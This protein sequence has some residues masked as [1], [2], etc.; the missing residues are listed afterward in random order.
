M[1]NAGPVALAIAFLCLLIWL[2]ASLAWTTARGGSRMPLYSAYRFDPYGSA[3]LARFLQVS[4]ERVTLLTHP[5]LPTHAAGVLVNITPPYKSGMLENYSTGK[6][7]NPPLLRWVA[8]GNALI[9]FTQNATGLT[10]HF[11]LRVAGLTWSRGP[12]LHRRHPLQHKK[13]GESPPPQRG[14]WMPMAVPRWITVMKHGESP[15]KLT[16]WMKEVRWK[17][18]YR[19]PGKRR[20]RLGNLQLLAPACF[21]IPKKD[22]HWKIL[23]ATKTGPVAIERPLGRGRVILVG[24]PWPVLNGGIGQ[25]GNLDF[26]RA[27]VGNKP[28]ILDQWSLGVGHNYTMLDVLRRYGLV[29]ALLELILLVVAYAWSCRGYPPSGSGAANTAARASVEHI[30]MLGQL[31]ENSLSEP[32]I[33][34]RVKNEITHRMAEAL[35][36]RPERIAERLQKQPDAVGQSFRL[37]LARLQTIERSVVA[38]PGTS[39]L[40]KAA[41]RRALAELMTQSWQ[42]AQEI[43]HGR[44]SGFQSQADHRVAGQGQGGNKEGDPRAGIAH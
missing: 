1:R 2:L 31:Y 6:H 7:Y 11:H 40:H 28:V 13:V 8:A 43:H 44:R 4:G 5:I 14:L 39:Q 41:R 35:R 25:A 34:E 23:A 37:M 19:A 29:P 15:H 42:L 26:L 24:S 30:A 18:R 27:L 10:E 22:T 21:I 20:K 36:S 38:T 32:E 9:D 33:L 3:A 16:R 17:H 12:G